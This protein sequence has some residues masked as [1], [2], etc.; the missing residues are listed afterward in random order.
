MRL[1]AL[2][3]QEIA[4]QLTVQ[5]NVSAAYQFVELFAVHDGLEATPFRRIVEQV[6]WTVAEPSRDVWSGSRDP[7]AGIIPGDLDF[8]KAFP[9]EEPKGQMGQVG[10]CCKPDEGARWSGRV[11]CSP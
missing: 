3:D 7:R 10:L 4:N 5:D 1:A 8:L 11:T 9:V 6:S 2:H